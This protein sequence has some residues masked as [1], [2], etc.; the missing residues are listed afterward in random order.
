MSELIPQY[1]IWH[2]D[3]LIERRTAEWVDALISK[4]EANPSWEAVFITCGSRHAMRMREFPRDAFPTIAE[5][6]NKAGYSCVVLS[7]IEAK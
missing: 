7:G 1:L 2:Q 4:F 3:V 5:Q 6:L